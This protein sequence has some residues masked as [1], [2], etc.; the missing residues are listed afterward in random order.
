LACFELEEYETAKKS[1]EIGMSLHSAAEKDISVYAR[2]IRKC[3][4]EIE[5]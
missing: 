3:D 1:F 5:G 4:A 2:W